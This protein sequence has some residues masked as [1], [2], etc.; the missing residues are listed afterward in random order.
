MDM[1]RRERVRH[2]S[3][4]EVGILDILIKGIKRQRFHA[5]PRSRFPILSPENQTQ[6]SLPLKV[7]AYSWSGRGVAWRGGEWRMR[8]LGGGFFLP[9]ACFVGRC[10]FFIYVKQKRREK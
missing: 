9:F 8:F 4:R 2:I 6:P 5:R 3:E 1:A 7:Y 10:L